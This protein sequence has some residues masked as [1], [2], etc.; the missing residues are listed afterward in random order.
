MNV[1]STH[2]DNN[3]VPMQPRDD[4]FTSPPSMAIYNPDGTYNSV[5][6]SPTMSE[7]FN[8]PLAS[9]NLITNQSVN[10]DLILNSYA[11]YTPFK[12]MTIKSTFGGRIINYGRTNSYTDSRLASQVANQQ[13]GIA[14]ISL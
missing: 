10:A 11:E 8:T 5:H 13:F 3:T 6:P 7:P 12:W 4:I 1:G 14:S 9:Q 2:T